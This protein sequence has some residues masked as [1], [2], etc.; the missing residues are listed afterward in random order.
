MDIWSYILLAAVI[1]A[2]AVTIFIAVYIVVS[3]LA[4]Q[5]RLHKSIKLIELKTVK[6]HYAIF[7]VLSG[8]AFLYF[9]GQAADSGSPERDFFAKLLGFSDAAFNGMISF[10]IIMLAALTAMFVLLASAKCAVMDK[11]IYTGL[12]F[13]GWYDIYDFLIDEKNCRVIFTVS[14]NTF[15]TLSGTTP[16]YKFKSEDTQKLVFICNKNK[17]SF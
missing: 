17:N 3:R 15:T 12:K 4:H 1:A 2:A 11:G 8:G 9:I 10:V 6:L 7:A 14:D 5:R 13:V 16:P